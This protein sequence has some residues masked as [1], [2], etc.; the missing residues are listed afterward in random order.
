FL[1]KLERLF[2]ADPSR[3]LEAQSG[4]EHCHQVDLG[5]ILSEEMANFSSQDRNKLMQLQGQ[6]ADVSLLMQQNISDLNERGTKLNELF[7]KTE[8]FEADAHMFESTARRVKE[9]TFW[10]NCRMRI[11]LFG[12]IFAIVLSILLIILWQSGVFDKK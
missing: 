11:I 10:E 7:D 2:V 12:A 4:S 8:Q 3:V 5:R 1:F 6:V 9:K